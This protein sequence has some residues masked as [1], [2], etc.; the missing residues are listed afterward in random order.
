MKEEKQKDERLKS[1]LQITVHHGTHEVGGSL[2]EY[3]CAGWRVFV[4]C[5]LPLSGTAC[6]PLDIDGLTRGDFSRSALLITH[7]HADHVGR[8]NEVPDA[9]PIYME[10]TALSLFKAYAEHMAHTTGTLGEHCAAL[11]RR[12]AAIRPF[13]PGEVLTFGPITAKPVPVAHSALGACGFLILIEHTNETVGTHVFHTGD[14]HL[15]GR[16]AKDTVPRPACAPPYMCVD[17]IVCEGTNATRPDVPGLTE[18]ELGQ[19]FAD[20]FRQHPYNFIYVSSLHIERLRTLYAAAR[21]AGRLFLVDGFQKRLLDLA[22]V[23]DGEEA[24]QTGKGGTLT[25]LHRDGDDFRTS[26]KFVRLLRQKGFCLAA[27]ATPCFDRFRARFKP[28]EQ[29]VILSMSARYVDAQ[30]KTC[31]R[32]SLAASLGTRYVHLHTSGHATA[33]ELRDMASLA[34]RAVIPIHTEQPERFTE[35]LGDSAYTLT[36]RDGESITPLCDPPPGNGVWLNTLDLFAPDLR[37]LAEEDADGH[38]WWCLGSEMIGLFA[39]EREALRALRAISVRPSTLAYTLDH[40]GFD[41]RAC[42]YTPDKKL[43]VSQP[44]A[45]FEEDGVE[46]DRRFRPGDL[47]YAAVGAKKWEKLPFGVWRVLVPARYVSPISRRYLRAGTGLDH[48]YYGDLAG[49][50]EEYGRHKETLRKH[51]HVVRPLIRLRGLKATE[52]CASTELFA[53]ELLAAFL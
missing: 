10:R 30:D 45:L 37:L 14:F 6:P 39:H 29:H 17:Y 36:L 35:C 28:E 49:L 32:P 22:G 9:V 13:T 42:V 44:H 48:C 3:A 11:A 31:Y 2:T 4:D 8:I 26:D 24:A 52:I 5:G 38:R 34:Y 50:V 20:E 51:H 1:P 21:Q 41:N 19:R 16:S 47:V 7:Y 15:H 43:Y 27:R 53:P 25:V 23:T 18:E 46:P 40:D 33:A 12:A